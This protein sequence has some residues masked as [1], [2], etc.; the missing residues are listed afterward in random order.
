MFMLLTLIVQVTA[1]EEGH[2]IVVSAALIETPAPLPWVKNGH[3]QKFLM[4][5]AVILADT[6]LGPI[7][8]SKK[9]SLITACASYPPAGYGPP[10]RSG[11]RVA[12]VGVEPLLLLRGPMYVV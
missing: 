12:A 8:L 5:Q 3:K 1:S 7:R 9:S 2:D 11:C 10:Y 4:Q 6:G